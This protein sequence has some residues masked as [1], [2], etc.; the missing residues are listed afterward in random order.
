VYV[1]LGVICFIVGSFFNFCYT[2]SSWARFG[3]MSFGLV[4]GLVNALITML[5]KPSAEL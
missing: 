2:L 5:F 4:L 1:V 3:S